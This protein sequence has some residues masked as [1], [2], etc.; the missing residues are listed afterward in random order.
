[1][2]ETGEPVSDSRVKPPTY[3][4]VFGEILCRLAKKDRRLVAITAAMQSGT[5]LEQFSTE[6]PDRFYDIG[7]AEQHAVTF[8]A[9]LALEGMKPVVAIY[10]TFLQ[11]AYDQIHQDVCLQN[12]PVVFALDRGGIVG[13]DGETHQGIFDLSYLRHIPNLVVMAPKDENELQHMIQ[14]AIDYPGPVAIRYPRG[15]GVGSRRDEDLQS[16]PIGKGE[17]LRE[18]SDLVIVAL[19]STVFPCLRAAEKLE[20]EGIHVALINSR[21][22]KP[23]DGDLLCEW[24]QRTGKVLTVEE[25]V[26]QGGFGSAILEVF[27]ER[28]LF[29]IKVERLGIPDQFVEHGPSS[30][31]RAK[32]GLDAE[33][34]SGRAREVVREIR[35]QTVR[36]RA[37]N[38]PVLNLPSHL[39]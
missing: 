3:T 7:I 28:G 39:K 15:R 35:S 11:R 10:S 5:G 38:V 20:E 36:P 30:L 9:G 6:F 21:F 31:L 19:G 4:E 25:N 23:L 17:V 14:T 8:A 24:A 22:L 37:D 26:L 2:V 1:M 32:Y 12:L 33:G 29:E 13:V 27:Q 34:I 16:L 18:G